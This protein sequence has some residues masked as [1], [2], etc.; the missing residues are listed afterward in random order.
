M[1]NE[2]FKKDISPHVSVILFGFSFLIFA[3]N[4]VR[5]GLS[6]YD[7]VMALFSCFLA[8]AS[9]VVLGITFKKEKSRKIAHVAILWFVAYGSFTTPGSEYAGL[10]WLSIGNFL[11]SVHNFKLKINLILLYPF[12]FIALKNGVLLSLMNSVVYVTASFILPVVIHLA[13][14]GGQ[15]ESGRVPSRADKPFREQ[16]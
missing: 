14:K 11:Y 1:K 16:G 12:V 8:I 13:Q 6:N 2:N 15:L 9:M 7:N 5:V 4:G 10:F 3:F